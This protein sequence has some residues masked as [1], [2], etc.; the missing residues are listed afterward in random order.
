MLDMRADSPQLIA[1]R[2]QKPGI[3]LRQNG[4]WN[5]RILC[6][7]HEAAIGSGDDYGVRF[8]R[9]WRKLGA[10]QKIV[11]VPNPKPDQL[12]RF[13]YAIVWR[14]A[15]GQVSPSLLQLGPFE[16][17]IF[18][19]LSSDG[20]YDLQ[21]L[22]G[23]SPLTLQGRP[24]TLAIAPYRDRMTIWNVIHFTL[25]GLDFYLKVDQRPFP[26]AFRPY[27]ANDN[28]PVII[29]NPGAR[30]VHQV[31]KLRPIFEQMRKSTWKGPQ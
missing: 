17:V 27:L 26:T 21:L 11:K 15:V 7:T 1:G 8:C 16:R 12:L 30:S 3:E 25:S 6:A 5:D 18:D 19:Q 14:H 20:P 31:P 9:R 24:L 13:A 10:G 29:S 23:A 4:E 22:I 2:R 28:D